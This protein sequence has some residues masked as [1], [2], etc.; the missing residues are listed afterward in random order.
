MVRAEFYKSMQR[1]DM[2]NASCL[3]ICIVAPEYPPQFGGV[4]RSVQ[5]IARGLTDCG[6]AITVVVMPEQAVVGAQPA[7]RV[8][9]E[10]GIE[11]Y[12]L[13]PPIRGAMSRPE[14][15][16]AY[17]EWLSGF[18]QEHSFDILQ[19][20]FIGVHSFL[21]GLAALEARKAFVASVRGDDIHKRLFRGE[22]FQYIRWT[23]EHANAVTFV[24]TEL[25]RRAR[26][27]APIRGMSCVIWNSI[28][29]QHILVTPD[30]TQVARSTPIIGCIGRHRRKKGVDILLEACS[31]LDVPFIV[32]LIGPFAE[33]EQPYW[34]EVL[35]QYRSRGLDIQVTEELSHSDVLTAY[36]EISV[37]AIPSL[38]DGCPN[39][40]LEG[41]S[42]GIPIVGTRSGAIG[43]I[44]DASSAGIVVKPGDVSELSSALRTMLIDESL[45]KQYGRKGFT[46]VRDVWTL[47]DEIGAWEQ[48]Y[49]D[50][51]T[52]MTFPLF[53]S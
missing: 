17:F 43:D 9:T 38:H 27:V 24:G 7:V 21:V 16:T 6:H 20:F 31:R 36:R 26:L 11:V 2:K 37:L 33:D 35:N 45:R 42:F 12:E 3:S 49:Q 8:R 29:T 40:L 32:R 47:K 18:I 1:N 41:L 28:D 25:E 48:L 5:R 15:T 46:F 39:V 50:V 53:D 30:A 51:L 19:S 44:L 13:T 10:D 14:L 34:A 52:S 23:L 22:Q 4:G